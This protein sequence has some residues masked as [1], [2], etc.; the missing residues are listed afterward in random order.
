MLEKAGED[1]RVKS[2]EVLH[3]VGKKGTSYIQ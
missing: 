3:T 1:D 2:E